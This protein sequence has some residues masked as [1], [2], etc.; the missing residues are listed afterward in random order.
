MVVKVLGPMDTGGEQLSPRER[1]LLAAL[2]VRMGTSVSASELADAWWGDDLPS[3]WAQQVRNSVARIRSRLGANAIVTA[4]SEYR[5]GIDPDAIDAVRFERTVSDA[6]QHALHGEHDRGVSAYRR[7]L[8]LWR[9]AP[10]QDVAAWDPGAVEALRLGEIRRSAE[11][12]LL[13]ARLA[14]GEHRAVIADAERLV[15][16]EPLR[17]DRWAILA[18]ANYRADRQADALAVLRAARTKLADELGIEPGAR[19]IGLEGAIL[20]QDPALDLDAATASVSDECPYPGLRAYGSDD[21]E[22]FFGREDDIEVV[23]ERVAPGTVVA[24]AGSSGTGKSSLVL[25]GVVPRLRGRGLAPRTIRPA[26]GG[27]AAVGSAGEADVLIIDQTEELLTGSAAEIDAFCM[28]AAAYLRDGGAI[29]CTVRSD[30][31]DHA[32][33]LPRL[34]DAIG[35]GVF[36]LGPL[37]AEARREA[38]TQPAARAGLR[39]EPGLIEVALRDTDGHP[40]ALPHLSHALQETWVRRE[41]T[42][43]TVR[44]YEDS[45]GVAGAIAQSAERA[46]HALTPAEQELCRSTMLRLLDRAADGSSTRRRVASSPL[47]ADPERRRVLERMIAARL[48]A[49][50]GADVVVAHEAV[51]AA[52]PRLD[53]WLQ[54]DAEAARTMRAV[55]LAAAEWNVAGRGDD[56]LLRGA[57]LQVALLWRE[58]AARDLTP[59][60]REF[61]DASTAREQSEIV[62]LEQRASRERARNRALR[63]AL[64]V[65]AGLLVVAMAAGGVAL[66]QRQE[67]VV[68]STG[69]R[70][71][72]MVA[73]SLAL[74]SSDRDTAAL[75]AV[76]AYRRW[77]DDE[78]VRSSLL[79]M[80]TGAE[81]LVD[82]WN[83][84]DVRTAAAVVPGTRTLLLVRDAETGAEVTLTDLD[85]RA[86]L[87]RFE[88]AVPERATSNPRNLAVSADGSTAVIQTPLWRTPDEA[89]T[90][91]DNDLVFVDLR[92][93]QTLPGSQLLRIRTSTNVLLE[94]D[95][96]AAFVAHPITGDLVRVDATTGALSASSPAAFEDYVGEQG[97]HNSLAHLDDGIVA[98]GTADGLTLHDA[99]TTNVIDRITIM[100]DRTRWFVADVGDGTI[101]TAGPGGI[102]RMDVGSRAL[103]WTRATSADGECLSVVADVA[104][105]KLYCSHNGVVSSFALTDGTTTGQR[106]PT[107]EESGSF[108]TVLPGGSEILVIGS[109]IQ[110]WRID[111]S[112]PASRLVAAGRALGGGFDASGSVIIA[113]TPGEPPSMQLWDVEADR[114]MGG[115]A[116]FLGW[117]SGTTY[118]RFDGESVSWVSHADGSS[119]TLSD[120]EV[121][122]PIEESYGAFSAL[123]GDTAFLLTDER[124]IP[125]DPATGEPSGPPLSPAGDGRTFLF[126]SASENL[127]G[128]RVA[129]TWFDEEAANTQTTVFDRS[130]GTVIAEGL[131]GSEASIITEDDELLAMSDKG[132][133]RNELETLAPLSAL[134]KQ[135]GGGGILQIGADTLLAIGWDNRASLYATPA[136]V[137]LGDPMNT[138]APADA[139]GAWLSQDGSTMVAGSPEGILLWD[140]DPARHAEAACAIADRELTE[141]E[142]R[143]YI[144]DEPQRSTCDG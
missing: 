70:V 39:I 100:A 33:A 122:G 78:R 93:G 141:A 85:T 46:F 56:D 18:L 65:A 24:V 109:S 126:L 73:T 76:E 97:E 12:E 7:A 15:R 115:P 102:A 52:W 81:G 101:L 106:L 63:G 107:Q 110:R 119:Y 13:D 32:R 127:A 112:G 58:S 30:A 72:A 124:L 143:T 6:R 59:L 37:T 71:E 98:V 40:T 133:T 91:C 68:A 2:V 67:A 3:T 20:R 23:L 83:F 16:E 79:G 137:R 128:T 138:V 53:G 136:G 35:R 1:T 69:A 92:S 142:W 129:V 14:A 75:L 51:A 86:E 34:G 123:P 28:A 96:S 29:V 11:E 55:E 9:G 36:L 10:L 64:G 89:S 108:V 44:G 42:T 17:E 114:P 31:L 111:G 118:E 99:D 27:A 95:G 125:F 105:E 57:R 49:F 132:L 104:R 134:P 5:L 87:R 103:L 25:A 131:H 66:V 48:V 4:G 50:D 120:E 77:P 140:L 135:F 61:L 113:E 74:R 26:A 117:I 19:L 121:F 90:C 88:V 94:G 47:L 38:I 22:W 21:A 139:S 43:L 41:G 60:E 84:G 62:A 82:K 54:D 116:E 144:G 80:M 45:G 130:D 8:A